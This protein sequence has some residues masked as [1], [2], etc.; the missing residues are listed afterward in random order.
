[1]VQPNPQLVDLPK[2]STANRDRS[3]TSPLRAAPKTKSDKENWPVREMEH[4]TKTGGSENPSA[5][6]DRETEA[7]RWDLS[8]VHR[9]TKTNPQNPAGAVRNRTERCRWR[10]N[11]EHT[12]KPGDGKNRLQKRNLLMGKEAGAALVRKI[13][14][15]KNWPV[16]YILVRW[17]PQRGQSMRPMPGASPAARTNQTDEVGLKKKLQNQSRTGVLEWKHERHKIKM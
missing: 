8:V 13:W 3:G 6:T 5:S 2:N 14:K 10:V 15:P 4:G 12:P 11:T 16:H 1:M 7:A 17:Q 9:G